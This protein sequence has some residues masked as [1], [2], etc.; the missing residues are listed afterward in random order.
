LSTMTYRHMNY[1]RPR[2]V[3]LFAVVAAAG[4]LAFAFSPGRLAHAAEITVSSAS[5]ASGGPGCTLRDAITAANTDVATGG[6][7]AGS[8]ADTIILTAGAAYTLTEV[9][10]VGV[11]NGPTTPTP[12][13]TATATVPA[14]APLRFVDN[15]DGTVTDKQTG[16]MWEQKTGTF[17]FYNAGVDCST[18]TC[19]DPH[20]VNNQYAW[21][22]SGT[23][24]DGSAFTDFLAR[25]N[26]TLCST[27]PCTGLGGHSDWRLPTI[28]ELHAILETDPT[29]SA[30]GPGRACIDQAFGS[31]ALNG[32]W[33]AT[34]YADNPA[35]AWGVWF[36][37]GGLFFDVKTGYSDRNYYVRAVRGT[38][39]APEITV[40]S[41]SGAPTCT[42]CDAITAAKTNI[43]VGGCPPG[44][45]ADTIILI[46]GARYT[47]TQLDKVWTACT[48]VPQSNGLPSVTSDITIVGNGATI[49]RSDAPGTPAFRLL[50]VAPGGRLTIND[51][52][53][54]NG[55]M[56][57]MD[58]SQPRPGGDG[59]GILNEGVLTL[60]N[61]ALT[62]N[63]AGNTLM[64][65]GVANP[66]ADRAGR[67]GGV[68]NAGTLTLTGCSVS[69]NHAGFAPPP[70]AG[71][72]YPGDGGGIY[73]DTAATLTLNET[74]ITA[75][76]AGD[77]MEYDGG[78]GGGI[79]NAGNLVVTSS[80]LTG[81]RAGYSDEENGGNGG[82]VANVASAEFVDSTVANNA[83]G[84]GDS[85][86]GDG[87]GVFNSGTV[88][89]T[90]CTISGNAAGD[91]T[92]GGSGGGLANRDAGALRLVNSTVS[93]NQA[94]GGDQSGD[95][96]GIFNA[97][98]VM[99]ASCTISGNTGGQGGDGISNGKGGGIAGSGPLTALKNT[100]VAEN[101]IIDENW[102][103]IAGDCDGLLTSQDYNLIQDLSNCTV[104]GDVITG[105]DP[106]L[107]PLQSNGGPTETQ[108][109]FPGSPAID[110]GNPS[111]CTDADGNA[112][113]TD[114]RG[115]PR[116]VSGD[117][118]CDIGAY[119]ATLPAWA[120]ITPTP[121][122]TPT[123]TPT[124][125]A[126][127]PTPIPTPVQCDQRTA[128][129]WVGSATGAPGARVTFAV[130]L[131][132]GWWYFAGTQND[133]SFTQ[134]TAV[135]AN[136]D[137]TPDCVVNPLINKEATAFGFLPPGCSPGVDCQGIRAIVFSMGIQKAILGD[138][139]LYQCAVDIAGDAAPGRYPL[140]NSNA[141]AADLLTNPA[142]LSP[143]NGEI[144]V[145]VPPA[146]AAAA[147]Q[148]GMAAP[149]AGGG[150]SVGPPQT[151]R[152]AALVF[153]TLPV[154]LFG[155]KRRQAL[156]GW[157]CPR[158]NS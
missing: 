112:L 85:Y 89:F 86:G 117:D 20:N 130:T 107:G 83:A 132:P 31:T 118:R 139:V 115:A 154:A 98:T 34:T 133:I 24:S 55:K 126:T 25:V 119:E 123:P 32:Y 108:A 92:G 75:N 11:D 15:G 78:S 129:L 147:S 137:G 120:T 18:T 28:W 59:G 100:L 9:D 43:G 149:A 42:L 152:G 153:L 131:L 155:R 2:S 58:L 156:G 37:D 39:Q 125:T 79:F 10:N 142:E 70:D 106:H 128:C 113:T 150:C 96:G 136:A 88:T 16:L 95:G 134:M 26:G 101:T 65:G 5:G 29:A 138:A 47:L 146:P 148:G 66:L 141:L 60:I 21:S 74:A 93:G 121:T 50:H 114:Q 46:A 62:A 102:A 54:T 52:T 36:Y 116:S 76:A 14:A 80:T 57:D 158:L 143:V 84:M 67:G 81:N 63:G 35:W 144:V 23:A 1:C 48:G 19:G 49:A 8:G 135:A 82:A 71:G 4:G 44:G 157:K 51:L 27:S 109:L 53:L 105:L 40:T 145:E 56:P 140:T 30:C 110:A 111:G 73:N 41:A 90:R 77:A 122:S 87:G 68:F 64:N 61:V 38:T 94:G 99:L 12:T 97:G 124:P 22:A 13:P 33:S 72:K 91:G 45:G 7:P 104:T 127:V 103:P 69:F 3:R 17:N 151:D 6:C